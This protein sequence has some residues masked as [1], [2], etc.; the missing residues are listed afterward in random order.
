MGSHLH[1]TGR[2]WNETW[3]VQLNMLKTDLTQHI[4]WT[5]ASQLVNNYNVLEMPQSLNS[6]I[7]LI[8][9]EFS[10]SMV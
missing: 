8:E 4:K 2:G 6:G 9:T 3:N 1:K 10:L 5:S 7:C